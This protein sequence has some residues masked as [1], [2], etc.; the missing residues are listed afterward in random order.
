MTNKPFWFICILDWFGDLSSAIVMMLLA[1]LAVTLGPAW[2][3]DAGDAS[4][5]AQVVSVTCLLILIFAIGIWFWSINAISSP[6][7]PHW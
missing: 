3:Y 1:A 6:D 2:F 7:D 4:T 5:I